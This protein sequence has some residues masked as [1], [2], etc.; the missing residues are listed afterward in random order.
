MNVLSETAPPRGR[1]FGR[2][3]VE[4]LANRLA[5]IGLAL[6]VWQLVSS[7]VSPKFVPGP[8]PTFAALG[9]LFATGEVLGQLLATL[10]RMLA[11]FALAM[12]GGVLVGI[13]MGLVRRAEQIFDLWVTVGLTIPSLCY[14]IVA[15]IWLGLNDQAAVLAIALTTFPSIAINV[16]QG[17]K[18]VDQRLIDMARVFRASSWRRTTRVVVPQVL[19][20]LMAAGRFGLGIVWKVTVFVEL[21]GRPNG[22]GYMLNYSF[23]M[24]N[25]TDV[26][27]WTLFFTLVM[28]A[29]ELAVLSPLERRLFRWRPQVRG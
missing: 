22:I 25:M 28:V 29:I 16:W 12:V 1:S 19:P 17:V 9:R 23:Q 18:A 7:F 15:F 6:L 10:Q 20:Y 13:L 24:F 26:F 3:Y 4:V 27:A 14:I 2:G 8:W 21:L 5:S 11:G